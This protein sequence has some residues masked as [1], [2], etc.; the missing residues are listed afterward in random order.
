VTEV[1]PAF[2]LIG[3]GA[4]LAFMPLLTIAMANVEPADAGMASGIINTS[5][6]LSGAVAVAVLGTVATE[7]TRTLTA[8]GRTELSALVGGY[9]LAF[10]VAVACAGAA[11]LAALTMLRG[12]A[13]GAAAASA[14]AE[15]LAAAT[16]EAE[17]A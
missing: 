17:A 4:G 10:L 13:P 14:D 11:V 9:H 8:G 3:L 12:S 5:L 1:L 7:R 2:V 6:Q 16:I 15:T